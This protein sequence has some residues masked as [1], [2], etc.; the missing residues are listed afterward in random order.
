[1]SSWCD[2]ILPDCLGPG[3]GWGTPSCESSLSKE[4]TF[5]FL[6]I[7]FCNAAANTALPLTS[8]AFATGLEGLKNISNI[9]VHLNG[10]IIWNYLDKEPPP[11]TI[12]FLGVE[13]PVLLVP[14]LRGKCT[15]RV[16]RDSSV[17]HSSNLLLTESGCF[18]SLLEQVLATYSRRNE[19]NSAFALEFPLYLWSRQELEHW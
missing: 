1:M 6:F 11:L 18:T 15:F 7:R 17:T 10:R 5:R 9:F 14:S 8:S 12:S 13:T 16:S 3:E 2:T 4:G 19:H